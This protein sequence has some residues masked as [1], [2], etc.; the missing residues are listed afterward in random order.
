MIYWVTTNLWTTGQGIVTRRMFPRTQCPR[1]R[2]GRV[3]PSR[4][5][6]SRPLR[7]RNGEAV[8]VQAQPQAR[9]DAG[10]TAEHR[11]ARRRRAGP[12]PA[13]SSLAPFDGGRR[14]ARARADERRRPSPVRRRLTPIRLLRRRQPARQSARRSGRR[15]GSSSAAFRASTSRRSSSP[16]SPRAN[17]A[18]SEWVLPR[19]RV[20][21]RIDSRPSPARSPRRFRTAPSAAAV[22]R[23][24]SCS[25]TSPQRSRSRPT[26]TVRESRARL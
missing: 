16:S 17:E 8:A 1:C 22:E 11:T 4:R 5:P 13:G 12:G 23:L 15:S 18:F 9:E 24:G 26:V 20:I 2:S 7:P 6:R 14:R 21:A 25:T 3:E 10:R 19:R